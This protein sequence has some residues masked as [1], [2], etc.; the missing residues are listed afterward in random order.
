MSPKILTGDGPGVA[1]ALS[2]D[3]S[4]ELTGLHR[5][6]QTWGY[7]DPFRE[8]PKSFNSR[9]DLNSVCTEFKFGQVIGTGEHAHGF[10]ANPWCV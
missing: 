9:W 4:A 6:Y 5:E 8:L 2:V 7:V 1:A 10:V 3:W